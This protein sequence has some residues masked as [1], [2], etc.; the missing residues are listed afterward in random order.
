MTGTPL[1]EANAKRNSEVEEMSKKSHGFTLIELLVVIAIIAILAA[2]LFPVFASAKEKARQTACASNMGQLARGFTMYLSDSG[3]KYPWGGEGIVD[4]TNAANWVYGYRPGGG[5]ANGGSI[6]LPH[7]FINGHDVGSLWPY[8]KSE[9]VYW[10]PSHVET[11]KFRKQWVK[12]SYTMNSQITGN[13]NISESNVKRPTQTVMLVD[14]GK[15]FYGENGSQ[16][17]IDD[18][19]F[20]YGTNFPSVAHCGG[21]NFA[22]CDGH[23]RFVSRSTYTDLIYNPN[24]TK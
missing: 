7:A 3:G 1:Y 16:M 4:P 18:G 11:E 13:F 5:S 8:I 14:E 23:V 24:G 19:Y 20:V 17:R 21:G 22:F 6:V 10:C 15:G 12:D 9:K 2:I